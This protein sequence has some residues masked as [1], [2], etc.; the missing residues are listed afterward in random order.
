MPEPRR[1]ALRGAGADG[2]ASR[3]LRERSLRRR[4]KLCLAAV[5]ALVVA[6]LTP[7]F[8]GRAADDLFITYRYAFNLAHGQGLVFNPGEHVFGLT[9]PGLA[10]L[11]AALHELTGVP[12]HLLGTVVFALAL[13]ALASFLL[14]AAR[15]ATEIAVA[16]VGGTLVVGS[17]LLWV[18]NGTEQVPALLL[19]VV[20]A[21]VGR[22]RPVVAGILA[23]AA[24]WLRPEAA[25]G[26]GLLVVLEWIEAK[27]F[28]WRL[29]VPAVAVIGLGAG[30]AELYYGSA[31]P[32]TF[33]AK[34]TMA[35]SRP[36]SFSGPLRFWF[37]GGR[38]LARHWGPLLPLVAALG[39]VGL[40]PLAARSHRP[41]RLVALYGLATAVAYPLL[42]V[43]FFP[44]YAVPAVIAALYGLAAVAVATGRRLAERLLPAY[45]RTARGLVSAVVAGLVLAVPL[46]SMLTVCVPWLEHFEGYGRYRTYRLAGEWIERHSKTGERIAYGEI[47]TLAYFSERPVDDLLGITTPR[48]LPYVRAHDPA[49]AFLAAPPTFFVEHPQGPH[50][51]L[52]TRPWFERG[53]RLVA[54]IPPAPGERGAMKIYRRRD[55][56][57]LPPPQGRHDPS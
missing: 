20:A 4:L 56:V 53:Y 29:V 27:R 46:G 15:G 57:P 51:G 42:G 39:V 43:P 5:W 26:V 13:W 36:G 54:T 16:A 38:V 47:G 40:W 25:I 19:L 52:V 3:H 7:T 22:R 8:L 21:M 18:N 33:E 9:N 1:A 24:V 23:G 41:L 55:G 34:R 48:S 6:L 32:A 49:G 17:T 35:E 12:V 30:L 31:F 44:W 10:L 2:D 14:V 11:L 45:R 50:R 37:R 28:P